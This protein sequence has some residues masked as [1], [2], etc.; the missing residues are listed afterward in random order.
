MTL[1]DRL[2]ALVS[3]APPEATVPVHWLAGLLAA[4][5]EP[6][7]A[8]GTTEPALAVVDLSVEDAAKLFGRKPGAVRAW[9]RN[10]E[11]PGSYRNH[12]KEWRIPLTAIEAMQAAQAKAQRPAK[13][14]TNNRR[15]A[16]IG[17]W[18]KHLQEKRNAS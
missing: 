2:A 17:E 15:T 16:D 7:E 12:G 14:K 1:R 3:A 8:R 13:P 11:L 4:E 5:A 9:A 6:G 10:G 18:R